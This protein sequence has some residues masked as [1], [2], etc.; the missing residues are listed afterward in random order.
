M[1]TTQPVANFTCEGYRTA[2][3]DERYELLD[4]DLIMVRAKH[5]HQPNKVTD[6]ADGASKPNMVTA[7]RA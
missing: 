1:G 4:G 2:P 6:H 5:G 3:A 7:V